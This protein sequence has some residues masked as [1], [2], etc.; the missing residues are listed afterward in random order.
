MDYWHKPWKCPFFTGDE[1]LILYCEGA[2]I[3]FPD[4]KAAREFL[5]YY[6]NR[7]WESCRI[8]QMMQDYYERME[9]KSEEE[10]K[11]V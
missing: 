9:S 1:S 2:K 3:K 10:N 4:K 5:F 11:R 7:N 8:A 6:C